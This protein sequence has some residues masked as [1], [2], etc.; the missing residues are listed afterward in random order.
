LNFHNF[1]GKQGTISEP[2]PKVIDLLEK[3]IN[4]KIKDEEK[5]IVNHLES[6]D[7]RPTDIRP[8]KYFPAIKRDSFHSFFN[9]QIKN[10][11]IFGTNS[12]KDESLSIIA[13]RKPN[14][15]DPID[16]SLLNSA[17]LISPLPDK[18]PGPIKNDIFKSHQT[19]P[20]S[21]NRKMI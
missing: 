2:D 1:I 6:R 5:P 16:P 17:R 20:L 12:S 21:I 4:V 3:I 13:S 15:Y 11:S 19:I 18:S 7:L 10:S 8:A 14:G 9:D